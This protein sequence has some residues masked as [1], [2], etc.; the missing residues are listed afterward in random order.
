[1]IVV[2]AEIRHGGR[3][4]EASATDKTLY[5]MED[6]ALTTSRILSHAGVRKPPAAACAV[7]PPRNRHP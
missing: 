2:G 3:P 6:M 4:W 7:R 1:M 5:A